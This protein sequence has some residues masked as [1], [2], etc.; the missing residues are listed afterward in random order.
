MRAN[1]VR[2]SRDK[3][4]RLVGH[5]C[6]PRSEVNNYPSDC[7]QQEVRAKHKQNELEPWEMFAAQAHVTSIRWTDDS[8]C[9]NARM[10]QGKRSQQMPNI[11]I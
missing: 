7:R 10:S 9:R 2:A 8:C 5:A 6:L 11:P 1:I 3:G 4:S